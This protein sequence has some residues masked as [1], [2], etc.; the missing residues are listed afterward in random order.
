[1]GGLGRKY[2]GYVRLGGAAAR[3]KALVDWFDMALRAATP[4]VS[5]DVWGFMPPPGEEHMNVK[6]CEL[7][8]IEKL[9]GKK[10][11]IMKPADIVVPFLVLLYSSFGMP[12]QIIAEFQLKRCETAFQNKL[13][14][15]KIIAPLLTYAKSPPQ[16]RRKLEGFSVALPEEDGGKQYF[17]PRPTRKDKAYGEVGFLN[18]NSYMAGNITGKDRASCT[19]RWCL[20]GSGRSPV[21]Y[22]DG[23]IDLFRARQPRTAAKVGTT[24]QTDKQHGAIF[25]YEAAKGQGLFF[26]YDGEGRFAFHPDGEAWRM[27]VQPCFKYLWSLLLGWRVTVVL[28]L[29]LRFPALRNKLDA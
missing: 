1:M 27:D 19:N 20:C 10:Q 9:D 29:V 23:S 13:Q 16:L 6:V 2:P 18:I 8:N 4:V 7:N 17:P 3:G 21:Q 14:Y 15:V 12:G 11:F 22:G 5:F 25:K 24:H 28:L 26:Q